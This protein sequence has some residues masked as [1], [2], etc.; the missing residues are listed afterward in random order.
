MKEYIN[1]HNWGSFDSIDKIKKLTLR[2]FNDLKKYLEMF[3]QIIFE[4]K[5]SKNLILDFF[6]GKYLIQLELNQI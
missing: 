4:A 5:I 2:N 6:N 1:N 3:S